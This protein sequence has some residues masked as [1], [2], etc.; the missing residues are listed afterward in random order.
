MGETKVHFD[1]DQEG[2]WLPSAQEEVL[3]HRH[4]SHL[5]L[6]LAPPLALRL[7]LSHSVVLSTL[8]PMP[9][10]PKI[11]PRGILEY[12]GR[13]EADS[14]PLPAAKACSKGQGA[15]SF[16]PCLPTP[17]TQ[18]TRAQ[19]AEEEGGGFVIWP[20]H[21]WGLGLALRQTLD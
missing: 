11:H 19:A 8:Y 16:S 6:G 1:G 13:P 9:M 5:P 21:D 20:R 15:R 10:V 17:P 4:S 2:P 14:F 12:D 18:N 7:I 3:G